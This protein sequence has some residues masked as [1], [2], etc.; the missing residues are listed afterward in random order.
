MSEKQKGHY[1]THKW[2]VMFTAISI[3]ALAFFSAASAQVQHSG[4]AQ[5]SPMTW[6]VLVG[7]EAAIESQEYGP[8]GAWQFMRFYPENITVNVG[9]KIVWMLK[10]SEPHTVTFPTPGEMIPDLFIPE[11]KSSLRLLLNP[12]AILHH[13]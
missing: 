11:N 4:A 8:S 1:L 2:I 9:D 6:T 10:G 13:G 12:L 3:L 7:G 5:T